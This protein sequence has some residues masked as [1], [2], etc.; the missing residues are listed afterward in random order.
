MRVKDDHVFYRGRS[1]E[2]LRVPVDSVLKVEALTAGAVP[3]RWR[4]T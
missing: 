2:S 3:T 1:E 4:S